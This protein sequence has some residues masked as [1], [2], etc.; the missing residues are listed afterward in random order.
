MSPSSHSARLLQILFETFAVPR[1][2][3]ANPFFA[4]SA[5]SGRVHAVVVDL[6]HTEARVACVVNGGIVD[7][8]LSWYANRRP[9]VRVRSSAE[10]AA[11]SKGLIV[12]IVARRR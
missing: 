7:G 11:G 10:N 9:S 6:G 12:A 1:M 5:A 4:V 2:A 8:T 3:F